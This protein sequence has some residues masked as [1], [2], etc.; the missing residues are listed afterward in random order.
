MQQARGIELPQDYLDFVATRNGDVEL[1]VKL[2]PTDEDDV[3][4]WRLFSE[5]DLS[6]P[7]EMKGVGTVAAHNQLALYVKLF[8]EVSGGDELPGIDTDIPSERV[9]DGFV[10]GED[11][12]DLLYLD[13][14]GDYSVWAF[15]H[16]GSYVE[17]V[18]RSF[19]ELMQRASEID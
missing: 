10:I 3:T 16:D 9:A 4:F 14:H 15:Y 13:L 11:N 1:E 6:Q 18:A 5:N 7:V 8:R 17:R 12:G 2:D 19:S